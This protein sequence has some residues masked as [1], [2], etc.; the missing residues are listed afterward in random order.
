MAK[1]C[2]SSSSSAAA[3]TAATASVDNIVLRRP[4]KE[5]LQEIVRVGYESFN[6][7][8]WSVGLAKEWPTAQVYYDCVY[9]SLLDEIAGDSYGIVAVNTNTDPFSHNNTANIKYH[10]LSMDDSSNLSGSYVL[11]SAWVWFYD[12]IAYIST[13]SVNSHVKSKGIGKQLLIQ[14]LQEC[15]NHS[16]KSIR[17]VQIAASTSSYSLYCGLGF[18]TAELMIHIKGEFK[19]EFT[20][21]NTERSQQLKRLIRPLEEKDF[22]A[23]DNF[24]HSVNNCSRLIML[25]QQFYDQFDF[26]YHSTATPE[27]LK[28]C[29]INISPDNTNLR[30]FVIE[31]NHEII[32]FSTGLEEFNWTLCKDET[33]FF[34]LYSFLIERYKLMAQSKQNQ[35]EIFIAVHLLPIHYPELVSTIINNGLR[36]ERHLCL[37]AQGDYSSPKNALYCPSI[38]W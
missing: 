37:L 13:V 8:N 32:A 4:K 12:G 31:Q 18:R 22:V 33:A 6:S 17:I 14:L 7:W 36:I 11:G 5:D 10:Q 21:Q 29:N 20:L 19:P 15:R 2:S 3:T 28:Q 16:V 30:C 9:S 24:F 38:E 35:H 1:N 25:K 27:E 26:N 23:C 34:Q